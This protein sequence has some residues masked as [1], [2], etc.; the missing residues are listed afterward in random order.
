MF[1]KILAFSLSLL[2]LTA[3]AQVA[4]TADNVK[5]LL[6]GQS[7]PKINLQSIDGQSVAIDSL[8][9]LKPTVLIF[10]RGGW[11]PYCNTHLKEVGDIESK[12]LGLGYQIVA[13]S[14][15]APNKLANTTEK[16]SLHYLLLSD[17]KTELIQKMGIA[18][19]APEKYK[20]MLLD[21]SKEGNT[22]G[23][24]PAPSVFFVD[25]TGKIALEYVNPDYKKRVSGK[26]ILA[27]A[28]ALI[29]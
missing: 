18:F 10:Y 16:D 17:S 29:Q 24:L 22:E 23:V 21:F 20:K 3:F 4:A 6:I 11:C 9:A 7:V 26:L 19:A 1:K 25:K 27:M 28:T 5:P 13:I 2:S 8:F 14:P 15:D 12:L